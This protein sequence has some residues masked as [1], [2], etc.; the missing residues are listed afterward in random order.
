MSSWEKGTNWSSVIQ[1]QKERALDL[2][3]KALQRI[4]EAN[5]SSLLLDAERLLEKHEHELVWTSAINDRIHMRIKEIKSIQFLAVRPEG[6]LPL[7]PQNRISSALAEVLR[8]YRQMERQFEPTVGWMVFVEKNLLRT[9]WEDFAMY[10]CDPIDPIMENAHIELLDQP[11]RV[12]LRSVLQAM[13]HGTIAVDVLVK[14]VGIYVKNAFR[15]IDPDIGDVYVLFDG[16]KKPVR[17][18]HYEPHHL[19]P[20]T[21]I[22]YQ[23]YVDESAPGMFDGLLEQVND[24]LEPHLIPD[25]CGIVFSYLTH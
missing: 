1:K 22:L 3:T 7:N 19:V 16:K 6:S 20:L 12:N 18:R 4:Q 8:I 2:A 24:L 14:R 13:F 5:N 15:D 23:W 11:L 25:I 21:K 10:V 17:I 9:S